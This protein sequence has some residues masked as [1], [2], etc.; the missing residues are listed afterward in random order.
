MPFKMWVFSVSVCRLPSQ[1]I[2]LVYFPDTRRFKELNRKLR[3]WLITLDVNDVKDIYD[4][5]CSE[6]VLKNPADWVRKTLGGPEKRIILVCS[7]LAYECLSSV[8]RQS[9]SYMKA[10]L[11]PRFVE[12][13]PHFGLLTRAIGYIEREMRGNYRNLICVR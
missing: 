13:D 9:Y 2:V 1:E 8:K 3:D 11:S 5:K 4:E 7:R 10:P 12:T 6:D